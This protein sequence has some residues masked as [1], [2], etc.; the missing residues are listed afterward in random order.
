MV[1]LLKILT[2][3]GT[4]YTSVCNPLERPYYVKDEGSLLFLT[5]P[6]S[7]TPLIFSLRLFASRIL[8]SWLLFVSKMVP[9]VLHSH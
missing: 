7:L 2:V 5:P 1:T 4:Q 6:I 8:S 3:G 9:C